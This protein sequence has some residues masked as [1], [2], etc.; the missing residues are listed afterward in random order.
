[1]E[2]ALEDLKGSDSRCRIT[3]RGVGSKDEMDRL[4]QAVGELRRIVVGAL[5]TIAGV[6]RRSKSPSLARPTGSKDMWLLCGVR[7]L[8]RGD[9]GGYTQSGCSDQ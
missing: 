8:P 3:E 9:D 4:A 2:I 1:M 6:T 7:G 5:G